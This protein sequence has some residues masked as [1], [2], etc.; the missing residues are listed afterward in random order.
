[1]KNADMPAMPVEEAQRSGLTKREHACIALRV[2][3]TGD[4]EID[5][6][7]RAAQRRDVA[8]MAMQGLIQDARIESSP[9]G[10]AAE[11]TW[12]AD[13]LLALNAPSSE[14][15]SKQPAVD[16][17]LRLRRDLADLYASD[18]VRVGPL[19]STAEQGLADAGIALDPLE[20][21]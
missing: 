2:P 14:Q 12:Y 20:T 18:P 1:M 5:A 17:L 11:A 10:L 6:L 21:R 19:I 15:T 16:A 13:A 3:E 8:A 7:I 9:A 4:P